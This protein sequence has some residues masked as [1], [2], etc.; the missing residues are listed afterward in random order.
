MNLPEVPQGK[1]RERPK[2]QRGKPLG[3]ICRLRKTDGREERGQLSGVETGGSPDAATPPGTREAPR[4][5]P[6]AP[7]AP[8]PSA[9]CIVLPASGRVLHPQPPAA[10]E[11]HT[12]PRRRPSPSAGPGAARRERGPHSNRLLGAGSGPRGLIQS[13]GIGPPQPP[14]RNSGSPAPRRPPRE[15][16]ETPLHS[17]APKAFVLAATRITI[18]EEEVP[19][20]L[21]ALRHRV[22][23]R[24]GQPRR[25]LLSPH[26]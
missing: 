8:A 7:R 11:R 2:G 19:R 17:A 4:R 12:P 18:P 20:L 26:S 25:H 22:R 21:V 24:S 23:P 16:P 15:S 10:R 14:A 6:A 1:H 9:R 3:G 13:A 5:V